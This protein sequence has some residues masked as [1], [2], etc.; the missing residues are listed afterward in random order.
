MRLFSASSLDTLRKRGSPEMEAHIVGVRERA[1]HEMIPM[2]MACSLLAS[3]ALV[4]VLRDK[5]PLLGLGLWFSARV[6][7]AAL[8]AAHTWLFL[9]GRLAGRPTMPLYRLLAGL[10]ALLWSALGWGLTPIWNLE[11]AV[12][13]VST[14]IGVAALGGFMLH[15]DLRATSLFIVPLM[16]PNAF[17]AAGRQDDIGW[18][19]FFGVLGL[20]VALLFEASRSGR[21]I[22]ELL[23]LRFQADQLAQAQAQALTEAQSLGEMKG[24]FVATMSH[25]MRTPLHGILG[26]VRMVRQQARDAQTLRHM[27]LIQGAGEHLVSVINDV[28]DFSRIESGGMPLHEQPFDLHALLDNVVETW[29]VSCEDKGVRME[30][31]L[32]VPPASQVQGDPVRLRQVLYNLLGNAVKFTSQGHVRL[33]VFRASAAMVTF[34]VEDTGVGIPSDEL[35]RIFEAFRQAEDTHRRRL[36]GSGLGLTISRELCVAMG[37]DLRCSSEEGV[38]SVFEFTLPLAKVMQLGGPAMP[39]PRGRGAPRFE[40]GPAP[41]TGW[42]LS[43]GP[44]PHVLLV[45]DNPVNALVAEAELARLGI[46]VT[47]L[48]NGQEAVDWLDSEHADLVLM[49][50]EM[51]VL[52]GL[53]ATRRIRER[54]RLQGRQ[55]VVIVALT[56]NGRE[57]YGDRCREVGM[58]DHLLKPFQPE[59]LARLLGRHLRPQACPA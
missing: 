10:D 48:G 16:L 20:M 36:G 51:P 25:E 58:N 2:A 11:V 33:S 7:I 9:T 44:P 13:T 47:V 18:Y 19:C 55:A 29:R 57:V 37:G 34:R 43:D 22:T 32:D 40:V 39:G 6:F 14:L 46:R 26:V 31:V 59:D 50:C 23:Q 56:A 49:D 41:F 38:G 5:V 30:A 42:T 3:L 12:I 54:E 21:R 52:D 17:Y 8:R 27:D 45:E 24:R 15:M 35:P 53:E 4:V 28:L 1:A